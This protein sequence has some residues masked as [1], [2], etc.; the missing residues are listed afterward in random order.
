[1]TIYVTNLRE[2]PRDQMAKLDAT[3]KFSVRQSAG[4]LSAYVYDWPDLRVVVN[5]MPDVE[6]PDHLEQFV[7]WLRD[8]SQSLGKALSGELA[9]RV[10]STTIVL[11]FVIEKASDRK[12]WHD[13]VQDMIGMICFNT[14]SI[15]FWEGMILDENCSQVWP[16]T[17]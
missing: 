16:P 5:V 11:G 7:R 12:V 6:R 17:A 9:A 10:R 1:M 4:R 2:L 14:K 3:G 15:V 13:R 8:R